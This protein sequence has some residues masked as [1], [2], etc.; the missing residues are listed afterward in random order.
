MLVL[1]RL[2]H[3][4]QALLEVIAL[5]SRHFVKGVLLFLFVT[6]LGAAWERSRAHAPTTPGRPPTTGRRAGSTPRP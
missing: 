5:T 6:T 2:V 3:I 4:K 1:H